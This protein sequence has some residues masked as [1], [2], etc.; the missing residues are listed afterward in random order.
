MLAGVS[1]LKMAGSVITVT[2]ELIVSVAL[3]AGGV[4]SVGVWLAI[5]ILNVGQVMS[6]AT[7]S[8]NGKLN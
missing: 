7:L 1:P 3:A 5:I 2:F 6:G 4:K 8:V